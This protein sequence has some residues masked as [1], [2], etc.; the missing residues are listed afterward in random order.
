MAIFF[1]SAGVREK[2]GKG[3]GRDVYL[4]EMADWLK[5]SGLFDAFLSKEAYVC[6]FTLCSLHKAKPVTSPGQI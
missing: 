1:F 3:L 4:V 6:V 5:I 2:S